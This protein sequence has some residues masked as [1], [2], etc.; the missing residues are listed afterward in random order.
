MGLAGG[1]GEVALGAGEKRRRWGEA[2]ERTWTDSGRSELQPLPRA[3]L[4]V[5]YLPVVRLQLPPV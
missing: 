4:S 3:V 2:L 5:T 1:T